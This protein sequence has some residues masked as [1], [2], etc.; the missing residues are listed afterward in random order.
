M[1]SPQN[2]NDPN[3]GFTPA[4]PPSGYG[5][6]PQYGQQYGYGP[7]PNAP[8]LNEQTQQQ[9]VPREVVISFWIWAATA[10]LLFVG[11]ILFILNR[12]TVAQALRQSP[13]GGQLTAQQIE[14]AAGVAVGVGAAILL[15]IAALYLLFAFKAKAGRNWARITLT[16]LT[17][18]NA[19]SALTGT[20]GGVAN[21]VG[22]LLAIVA[23]VLLYMPS[24]NAYYNA[25]KRAG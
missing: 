12:E 7:P 10:A 2:P 15:I 3:A 14:Q 6:Q 1:S 13:N 16:V 5:Q 18:L 20:S 22:L 4:P 8:S 23:V 25:M 21:Y 9:A 17:V 19:L 11:A 24:S